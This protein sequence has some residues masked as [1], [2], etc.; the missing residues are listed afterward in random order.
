MTQKSSWENCVQ[1]VYQ[2]LT[3]RQL[4]RLPHLQRLSPDLRL[5][6]KAVATVLPFRVN[7]YVIDQLIDWDAIPDDPI[8]QLTF[9]QPGMLKKPHL[10]RLY[11]LLKAGASEE[12]LHHVAQK[13][14]AELN[15]HPGAQMTLNV[16]SVDGQRLAGIQHSYAETV[17]FF[18]SPGQTCHAYCTYCFRWAQF[19]GDD[20]LKMASSEVD[21]LKTYLASHPAV[22]DLLVTG[23]DPLIMKASVLFRFLEPLL[24]PR[25]EHLTTIRIGTKSLAY[26]PQRFVT[27]TDADEL[28]GV[29]ERIVNAGKHLAI[30]A[31]YSHPVELSTRIAREAVQ[32]IQRTGALIRAQAPLIHH[33]NDRV[34]VWRSLWKTEVHL[35]IIPYYMFQARDT[36]AHHYF[37]VPLTQAYQIFR[38]AYRQVSGLAR[39]VRGPVMSTELGKVLVDGIVERRDRSMFVLRFLQARNADWVGRPFFAA[40]D[41]KATW[42]SELQPINEETQEFFTPITKTSWPTSVQTLEDA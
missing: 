5:A 7:S 13:I 28:L 40:Y 39:T 4:D 12:T 42:F 3:L 16:P 24:D 10:D 22:T 37:S 19:V 23:G 41:S 38:G 14:R 15:P 25:L 2:P 9:P 33:V 18:P 31:H 26:W 35:G 30:M 11:S 32:R 27:D 17:L 34:D 20:N 21:T 29:F 36:G 1:G 6:M 8:F